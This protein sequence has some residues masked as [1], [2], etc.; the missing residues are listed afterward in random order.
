MFPKASFNEY[1]STPSLLRYLHVRF[2]RKNTSN[3]FKECWYLVKSNLHE[4]LNLRW[5]DCS[6]EKLFKFVK[7]SSLISFQNL[8]S[9]ENYNFKCQSSSTKQLNSH[10]NFLFTLVSQHIFHDCYSNKYL[11]NDFRI[12]WTTIYI[13]LYSSCMSDWIFSPENLFWLEKLFRLLVWKKHIGDLC[14]RCRFI[15]I[16]DVLRCKSRREFISVL[17]FVGTE[18]H[19]A[20]MHDRMFYVLSFDEF[21]FLF[22]W[23][24]RISA[25]FSLMKMFAFCLSLKMFCSA[26]ILTD[27]KVARAFTLRKLSERVFPSAFESF[28]SVLFLSLACIVCDNS[29]RLVNFILAAF[30]QR[31]RRNKLC[32]SWEWFVLCKRWR[33]F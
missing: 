13:L 26:N 21:I 16:Y 24:W 33:R 7:Y 9:F 19:S 23:R 17:F 2:Y 29:V 20:W 30:V 27:R 5:S 28:L 18:N 32:Q 12:K 8:N 15:W 14:E 25:R 3:Y 10:W 6:S 1:L 22:V 31:S 11:L 4:Y